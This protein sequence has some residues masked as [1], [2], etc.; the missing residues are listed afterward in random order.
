M[1]RGI[2]CGLLAVGMAAAGFGCVTKRDAEARA[3]IAFLEGQ[4]QALASRP[5]VQGPSV[6]FMGPVRNQTVPWSPSLTLA[7]A[8][9]MAG[10]LG[11]K[12]PQLIIIKRQEEEI[13]VDPRHLLGGVDVPLVMGDVIEIQ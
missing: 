6:S 13:P 9:V 11:Q 10:Y 12:D 7:H 5:A 3:H 8:L 1:C 4:R 2:T